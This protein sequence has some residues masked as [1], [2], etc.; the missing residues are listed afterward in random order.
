MNHL[1]GT[2][3]RFHLGAEVRHAVKMVGDQEPVSGGLFDHHLVEIAHPVRF[4]AVVLAG[5]TAQDQTG[6]DAEPL[7]G[8]VQLNTADIVEDDVDPHPPR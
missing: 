4:P 2:Q 1:A 6:T 5:H 3:P 8:R 7:E